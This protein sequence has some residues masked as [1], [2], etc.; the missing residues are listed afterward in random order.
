LYLDLELLGT[1]DVGQRTAT[2]PTVAVA[3]AFV[4]MRTST[5]DCEVQPIYHRGTRSSIDA[6]DAVAH[7]LTVF[8]GQIWRLAVTVMRHHCE[9]KLRLWLWLRS[10]SSSVATP[11][12]DRFHWTR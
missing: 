2:T 6:L 4:R 8:I 12:L 9:G 10:L 11:N 5:A 1:L 7:L 3:L